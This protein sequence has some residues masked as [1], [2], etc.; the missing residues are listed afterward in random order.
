MTIADWL[1]PIIG[2]GLCVYIIVRCANA[3]LAT[4]PDPDD[5]YRQ[6]WH[7]DE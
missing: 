5:A 4:V 6:Y 1:V 2:I 3:L 7:R